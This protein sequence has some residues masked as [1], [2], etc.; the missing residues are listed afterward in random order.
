MDRWITYKFELPQVSVY[1]YRIMNIFYLWL[2]S[3]TVDTAYDKL[4]A[5][6]Q[7]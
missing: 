5:K 7:M 4:A 3:S 6:K 1:T 2:V